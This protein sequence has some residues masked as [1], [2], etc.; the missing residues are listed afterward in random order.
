MWIDVSHWNSDPPKQPINWLRVKQAGVERVYIKATE[1]TYFTDGWF[2]RHWLGSLAARLERGA[3]H[4]FR[5]NQ[6]GAG[7]ANYFKRIVEAVGVGRGQLPLAVDVEEGSPGVG[8]LVF[9]ARLWECLKQLE[10]DFGYKPVIYTRKSAWDRLTSQPA[11]VADY[12]LWLAAY[13]GPPALPEKAV[14][15]WLH[16][17]SETG[18]V[19][20][21]EG[22]VDL[23][24]PKAT[25]P[26]TPG[27][28]EPVPVPD[29]AIIT[30]AESIISLAGG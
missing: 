18:R 19:D 12:R 3:Y 6:S 16:Q 17:Y 15:W 14:D 11:W 30:H 21:I 10:A 13:S 5:G 20:G 7:Q 28:G 29:N 27:P 22:G 26:G 8:P 1:S 23:N 9:T 24:R 2:S 25:V 4:F